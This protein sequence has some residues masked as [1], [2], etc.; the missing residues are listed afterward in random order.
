MSMRVSAKVNKFGMAQMPS[1]QEDA[2]S[3]LFY[4]IIFFFLINRSDLSSDHSVVV[5]RPHCIIGTRIPIPPI[6]ETKIRHWGPPLQ[7]V[8]Q[9]SGQDLSGRPA[10]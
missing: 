1:R 2:L 10:M 7:K 6:P 3:I 4:R 5:K 9:G 8:A